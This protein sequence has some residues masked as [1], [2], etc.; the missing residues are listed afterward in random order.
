MT[1]EHLRSGGNGG[2]GDIRG[3]SVGGA[4]GGGCQVPGVVCT[5]L[6]VLSATNN[7]KRHNIIDSP[8]LPTRAQT[9]SPCVSVPHWCRLSS[10]V[11]AES[12]DRELK[13]T[14]KETCD[15]GSNVSEIHKPS[16]MTGERMQHYAV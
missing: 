12:C 16:L 14:V 6:V 13:E 7:L 15:G 9:A 10:V 1:P 4:G 5:H 3:E 2:G 8:P 11:N